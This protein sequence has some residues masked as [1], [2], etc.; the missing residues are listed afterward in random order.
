MQ[1]NNIYLSDQ[2]YSESDTYEKQFN[3]IIAETTQEAITD[4]E[5]CRFRHNSRFSD[6]A[7]QTLW[8]SRVQMHERQR[9]WSQ[10]LFDIKCLQRKAKCHLRSSR[11]GRKCEKTPQKISITKRCAQRSLRHQPRT[12]ATRRQYLEKFYEHQRAR[13][14]C[15]SKKRNGNIGCQ[16]AGSAVAQRYYSLPLQGD[17]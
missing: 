7:L 13:L 11:S 14:G 16:Y 9:T 12:S 6:R 1:H 4:T 10:I 15:C 2:L 3:T 17:L 8:Q 5:G